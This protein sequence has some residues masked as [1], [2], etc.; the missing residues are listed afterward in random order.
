MIRQ[1]SV[2]SWVV[3]GNKSGRIYIIDTSVPTKPVIHKTIEPAQIMKYNL[4][5][6]HTVHCL[7][8]GKIMISMLGDGKMDAPGGFLILDS[9]FNI[10][11]RWNAAEEMKMKFNNDFWYQPEHNVMVS[12]EFA[13]P[14][15]YVPGF[16]IT[17]LA[18]GKYGRG[19]CFWNWKNR[20]FIKRVDLGESGNVSIGVRFLH[21]PEKMDGFVLAAMGSAIWHITNEQNSWTVKKVDQLVGVSKTPG[22]PMPVPSFT[23]DGVIS[24][25][26]RFMYVSNWFNGDIRQYDISKPEAPKLVGQVWCGESH[27]M[28]I[29]C[30]SSHTVA[31]EPGVEPCAG[32]T[33][34]T[35]T[36]IRAKRD[37]FHKLPAGPHMMQLSLDGKRLY[38]TN[39]YLSSW[40]D[41]FFPKLKEQGSSMLRINVN[42]E[43]GGLEIDESFFVD[44]GS[45]GELSV[46]NGNKY[47]A[48]EMHFPGGDCT[49]EIWLKPKE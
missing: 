18:S 25:D 12:A 8:D 31:G 23:G 34:K 28:K 49:S 36:Q 38:V 37:E 22:W 2:A 9:D 10:E 46:G 19:I 42:T 6:P 15:D 21:N 26:D 32:H 7:P 17:D 33:E 27:S 39:S 14:K 24:L 48:H 47:R 3:P 13:A 41:K 11:G 5:A 35:G 16:K 4:S 20:E 45:V 30:E 1:S 40:D 43:K 44:F 29:H